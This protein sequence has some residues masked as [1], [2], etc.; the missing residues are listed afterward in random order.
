MVFASTGPLTIKE[1]N[2]ETKAKNLLKKAIHVQNGES[3]T[4]CAEGNVDKEIEFLIN[5]EYLLQ[6]EKSPNVKY[7]ITSKGR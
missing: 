7:E 5:N 3:K 1:E 2:L 4:F 6:K